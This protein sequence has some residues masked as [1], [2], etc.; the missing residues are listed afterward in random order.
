MHTVIRHQETP[1][2]FMIV[3]SGRASEPT[4]V[5]SYE[6]HRG[7]RTTLTTEWP[8]TDERDAIACFNEVTGQS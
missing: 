8:Y 7:G 5:Q 2:G 6:T 4:M 1:S 3:V